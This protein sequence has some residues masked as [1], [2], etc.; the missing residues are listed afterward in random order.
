MSDGKHFLN[1]L[2]DVSELMHRSLP[3]GMKLGDFGKFIG[4]GRR[5]A[6]ARNRMATISR[7]EIDLIGLT[8][9]QAQNWVVAYEAVARL[10]PQNPSAAG[11][12]ELMEHIV[13]LLKSS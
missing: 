9:E 4:W 11:R 2:D 12:L 6:E 8:L 3:A 7:S 5:S 13:Q 10:T 1:D